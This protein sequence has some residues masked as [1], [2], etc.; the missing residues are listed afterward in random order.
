MEMDEKTRKLLDRLTSE[1][2]KT[3]GKNLK[4]IILYGSSVRGDFIPGRSDVN[5]MLVLNEVELDSLRKLGAV[6]RKYRRKGFAVP[7]VAD[8]FYLQSSLDVFP[9]EWEEI[10]RHHKLIYG[11]DLLS[12]INIQQ[13]HLRLQLERE[14]KQNLLWLRE[15][16]IEHP[17]FSKELCQG[18]LSASRS[19]YAHLRA[20]TLMAPESEGKDIVLRAEKLTGEKFPALSWL[21]QLRTQTKSPKKAELLKNVPR[22]LQ[23][24]DLLA[25]WIDRAGE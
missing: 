10:K 11:E 21:I 6:M 25:K 3:L 9:L 18:L 14:F 23:E 19:L 12:G 13:E 20:L 16:M 17:D 5:L 15:L 24:V 2:K 4:A 1:L 22:L 8:E 7:V